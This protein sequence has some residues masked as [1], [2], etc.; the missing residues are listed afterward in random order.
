MYEFLDRRYAF[1][2]YKA[3]S[4]V[5][6]TDLVLEQLKEI[7]DELE[8]NEGLKK[9]IK[10]PRINRYNKKRIF[11]EMFQED[12]EEELLNF[13]LLLIDKGRILYLKE[14]YIQFNQ[15]YLKRHNTVLAKVKSVIPLEGYQKDKLKQK[16]E[17]KY[18]KTIILEEEID[19]LLIGGVLLRVGN[20]VI[21]GSIRGKLDKLKEI[22]EGNIVKRYNYEEFNKVLKAIVHTSFHLKDEEAKKLK[23]WLK[24][25]YKREINLVVDEN[26]SKYKDK[27]LSVVIGEDIL[28]S[29]DI[30]SLSSSSG[31]V[32][33][34]KNYDDYL[35]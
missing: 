31:E 22:A 17:N 9:I 5:G 12:I 28:T 26:K 8:A 20:E 11:K 4:E 2:L 27:E 18:K 14:K 25:F 30:D 29:S 6:N 10:N 34:L 15:I 35:A 33:E 24:T 16:L 19:K 21:D 3:C 1:A 7:V 32:R 23:E 13:L